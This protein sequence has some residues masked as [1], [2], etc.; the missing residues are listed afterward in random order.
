MMRSS[1]SLLMLML[2]VGCGRWGY[3]QLPQDSS[4][5]LDVPTSDLDHGDLVV[6]PDSS[7]SGDLGTPDLPNVVVTPTTGLTTTEL[8]AAAT[9]TVALASQPTASVLIPL[10]SSRTD[11]GTVMPS[12]LTFTT[13]N[14]NAPQTV[15]VTGVDDVLADGNQ[16]YL[17][18]TAPATSDD[19]DYNGLNAADVSVINVD[20][21][22]AGV[23]VAPATGLMTTENGGTDTFGV[24]LNTAPDSDVTI[25]FSSTVVTEATVSPS[26][27]FTPDNWSAMQMVTVTGVDDLLRDGDQSFL[28]TSAVTSSDL[29][30]ASIGVLDVSGINS[31]DETPGII[32]MPTSGLETTEGGGTAAFTVVLQAEPSAG[33]SIPIVST[34][35]DEGTVST[36]SISFSP[37]DWDMP[38]A[39]VVT[40]QDDSMRDGNQPFAVTLGPSASVDTAYDGLMGSEVSL[41]NRD[42]ET[43]AFVLSASAPLTTTEAGGSASFSVVLGIAP[44]GD[45][46]FTVASSNEDEGVVAP[47]ALTF[48]ET[49]WN[50][51]QNVLVSG[52]DD[53]VADGNQSYSVIVHVASSVDAEYAGLSDQSVAATNTDDETPGITVAPTS[54]LFT[55]ENGSTAS[56]TIVLNTQPIADVSIGI[57]SAAPTEGVANQSSVTFTAS[58]WSTPQTITV[59]GVDDAVADGSRLYSVVTASA[60][61]ADGNYNGL[62]ADDVTL[63]NV[64]DDVA[65]ISMS[66][67][68]GL[69]TTESG[70]T[71][72]ISLVLTSEPSA[73]VTV[74]VASTDTTEGTVAP[75]TFVFTTA[76]WATPQTI[77]VT[78]VN[79]SIIDGNIAYLVEV[80]SV[81]TMDASYAAAT[82]PSAMVLNAD[83]D[84][85][86]VIVT[87]ISGL[88]TTEAGATATFAMMLASLPSADVTISLT[89]SDLTEGTVAPASVTFT[90][91]DWNVPQTVTLTGVDDAVSDGAV[92][93]SIVTGNSTSTDGFY[94]GLVVANVSASNTDN[95][96]PGVTVTPTSGLV[97]TESAGTATFT[98]VLNTMPAS[99]VSISLTSGSPQEGFVSP[100]QLTFTS[101]NWNVPQ[102]VTVTG[103]DD[104]LNDGDVLYSII[105]GGAVSSD[106]V[107]SG[108]AVSDVTV[109]NLNNEVVGVVV[110]PTGPLS[111]SENGLKTSF[112]VRLTSV[113]TAAVNITVASTNTAEGTVSASLLSFATANW[114]APQMV[115]VTGVDDFA[116]DGGVLYSITF[117]A[118][119]ADTAYNG[120]AIAS[121]TCANSDNDIADVIVS[122][123]ANLVVTESAMVKT[124]RI[125]LA[126]APSADVT[127]GLT[128]SDLTEGTVSPA[129]VTFTTANWSSPQTVSVTGVADG[130]LD[131]DQ[132]F[133]IVT[134]AAT[135]TDGTFT[136]MNP[137]DVSVIN[138]DVQE[139]RCASCDSATY[140]PRDGTNQM[141]GGEISAD[142][143]YVTFSSFAA[144]IPTD[145]DGSSD[146][147]VRD[148]QN[149]TL[150]NVN[151][152]SAGAQ[153]A[154]ASSR[155]RITPDGRYVVFASAGALD[156]ADTNALDDIYVRDRMLNTVTR[157]SLSDTGAQLTAAS[158]FATISADGRRVA[159]IT[160]AA[161]VSGDTN[162]QHDVFVRDLMLNTTVRAS[163][164]STG[165]QLAAGSTRFDISGDGR[166]VAFDAGSAATP[167]DT[168]LY[169]DICVRDLTLG[170]TTLI[171]MSPAGAPA[172]HGSTFPAFS[173]DGRYLSFTSLASN[174]VAGDTNGVYDVFL[175]DLMLGTTIRVS[176]ASDGTQGN[177]TSERSSVSNDGTRVSFRS[178]ATNL[179]AGD[180][181][182]IGDAFVHDVATGVTTLVTRG[183]SGEASNGF[184]LLGLEAPSI[185]SDGHWIAYG[186]TASN[187]MY[188]TYDIDTTATVYVFNVP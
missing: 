99:N 181:N 148:R 51:P 167:A 129:S 159:F 104:L 56:F 163:V 9:F 111:T 83:N 24:V 178:A 135:S 67:T 7:P 87:P 28:I 164:S 141:L 184:E 122:P 81:V 16:S 117:A 76:D 82:R 68:T 188:E 91:G 17:V 54:G 97:T 98:V 116:V 151:I 142:G 144:L 75:A 175:H 40:G 110:T 10:S 102:T 70:G 130:T 62:N 80:S 137:P 14:W 88:V 79:D 63:T 52:I 96:V 61:S 41:T 161:A 140:A 158:A 19:T 77:T 125:V 53:L 185:S 22:T 36:S 187:M 147:Y 43:A 172:N 155:P 29:H 186:T 6:A 156:P 119:S 134:A 48:D 106:P 168:N 121:L 183:P 90:A 49:T 143:R 35:T 89:S 162:L 85:A 107:Y 173:P 154:Q 69:S 124:F 64:D 39:I 95:D 128:S 152:T 44:I 126:R 23:T 179:V 42:D 166:Y 123:S 73:T 92:S 45:V 37:T 1:V 160:P 78:G 127:I 3:T 105:T 157:A 74:N 13:A 170:T 11:E 138:V 31:D 132:T 71:A 149:N 145:V 2:V 12:E 59:A 139:Q 114:Y 20:N 15:T 26:V 133:S 101:L 58:A 150:E 146:I 34:A 103:A 84:A 115:T 93:Y 100:E 27:V 5:P 174:L 60:T 94:N 25:S 131:G 180:T 176:V 136:G 38:Q 18:V 182:G 66:P 108:R 33:V 57:S 72:S 47:T 21:E 55:G 50:I 171:T 153:T 8:G 65:S 30:Y 4:V 32:V 112:A 118:A 46:E 169:A 165:G 177:G 109:T 120:I 86:S 113:P